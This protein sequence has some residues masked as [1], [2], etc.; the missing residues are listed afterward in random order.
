MPATL[1]VRSKTRNVF[2]CSNAWTVGSSPT[3][4]IDVCPRS[5]CVCV[6]LYSYRPCDGLISRPKSPIDSL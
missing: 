4:G 3:R 6:V 2:A 1:A 5:F